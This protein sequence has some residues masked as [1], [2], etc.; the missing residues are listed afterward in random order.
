MFSPF[1]K[2]TTIVVHDGK[3][4]ADDIFAC[5]IV[6][7]LLERAGEKYQIVRTRDEAVIVKA[8]FVLDVGSV[9]DPLL[10]RFDHHQP[11]GAGIRENGVPYAAAGLTW[12]A[13]GE[14]LSGSVE[15]Q[16]RIDATLIQSIDA[17]DNGY[18]LIELK[19]GIRPYRLQETLYA[20]RPTWKEA[21]DFDSAFMKLVPLAREILIR[22]I[23]HANDGILAT[24]EVQ[25][26][27]ERAGDKRIIELSTNFPF[28]AT[29]TAHPEPLYV[30]NPRPTGGYK[31]EAVA[32]GPN[33][34]DLRKPMPEAWAGLRGT[35]LARASG[36]PDAIFCHNGRFM[37]VTETREGA[38][39]LARKA[40]EA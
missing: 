40:A 25:M 31:V 20:F 23:A 12:K 34:F 3:F 18:S 9:H 2:K 39:L 14:E 36:V 37:A 15:A 11:G 38:L 5:A 32:Q 26:A 19:H 13:Y 16:A 24:T 7:L 28:Q 27:Y 6:T 30:V 1:G 4:H 22:E 10:K 29:L 17:D 33:T 8:D 21:Q 35:D